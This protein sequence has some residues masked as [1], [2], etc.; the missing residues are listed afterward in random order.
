MNNTKNFKLLWCI[1]GSFMLTLLQTPIFFQATYS[2][3]GGSSGF[4][5][6]SE[7]LYKLLGIISFIGVILV[8]VFSC[9]LIMNNIKF[10][11]K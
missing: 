7:V 3:F 6:F 4:N 5:I 9:I 8:T 2:I 11:D 1:L 10:K